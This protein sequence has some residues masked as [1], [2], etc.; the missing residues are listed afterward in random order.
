MSSPF[1]PGVKRIIIKRDGEYRTILLRQLPYDKQAVVGGKLKY[2][3][4]K[5]WEVVS[6]GVPLTQNQVR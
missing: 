2:G 5:A 6:T 1:A 3:S 4:G